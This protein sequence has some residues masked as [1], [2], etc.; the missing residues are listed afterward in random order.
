MEHYP[1]AQLHL[2]ET[3]EVYKF[4]TDK[5]TDCYFSIVPYYSNALD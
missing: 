2:S 5:N 3:A 1:L 4:S